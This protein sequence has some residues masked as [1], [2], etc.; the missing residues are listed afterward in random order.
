LDR[1]FGIDPHDW[2]IA[3]DSHHLRRGE[4]HGGFQRFDKE[5]LRR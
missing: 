5:R 4:E 2:Q 3:L 1:S